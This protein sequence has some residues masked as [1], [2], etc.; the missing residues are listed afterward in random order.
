[1]NRTANRQTDRLRYFVLCAVV[2][3]MVTWVTLTVVSPFASG[4]ADAIVR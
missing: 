3:V 1:M 4:M 2:V